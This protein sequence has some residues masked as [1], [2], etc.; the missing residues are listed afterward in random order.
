MCYAD[1]TQI[2]ISFKPC[3]LQD[4]ICKVESCVKEI[5]EWSIINGLK[6]NDQKTEILHLSSRFR[7]RIQLP[8]VR[9]D[10]TPIVP[11]STA[12]NLGVIFD[13]HMEMDKFV[14][15]K[16]QS[17]SFALHKLGMVR[18]FLDLKTTKK[19]VHALVMCH[20]DYCN[21]LLYNMPDSQLNR[22]Q[23]IQNSAAR[24]IT[25]TKKYTHI[26]PVLKQLHWLPVKS[27]IT[28]KI[29]LITFQC[30][31]SMAPDYLND[32][33]TKYTPSRNLRSAK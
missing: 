2:Y 8:I 21:S 9:I 20:V 7:R 26:T 3:D 11:N 1:D 28:F 32:S 19:L 5:Q 29:I 10:N 17:A 24:L 31:N 18:T 14:S 25:R 13:Q 6:L 27:R 33:L 15:T 4:A 23:V 30:L 16:C 22:L 12:R